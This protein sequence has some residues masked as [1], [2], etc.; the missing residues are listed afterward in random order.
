[1]SANEFHLLKT[2]KTLSR[3]RLD[4]VHGRNISVVYTNRICKRFKLFR[5]SKFPDDI[6]SNVPSPH[7]CIGKI[8]DRQ[9]LKWHRISTS[10]WQARFLTERP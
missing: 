6:D 5:S 2:L 7:L 9:S 8:F 1:M 10:Q 4:H 3:N